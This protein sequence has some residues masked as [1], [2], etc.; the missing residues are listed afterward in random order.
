[1]TI[2]IS[3][4]LILVTIKFIFAIQ[5]DTTRVNKHTSMIIVYYYYRKFR[6][7]KLII[8]NTKWK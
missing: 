4:L 2:A 8:I 5:V 3:L 1:M 7:I 6:R